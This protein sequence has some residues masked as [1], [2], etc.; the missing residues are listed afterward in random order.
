MSLHLPSYN[1][2]IRSARV[3]EFQNGFLLE[4]TPSFLNSAEKTNYVFKTVE[5]NSSFS[6]EEEFS[7]DLFNEM[8]PAL[9]EKSPSPKKN[10][11]P[12]HPKKQKTI[13]PGPK[14]PRNVIL[15]RPKYRP[16][17]YSPIE[18]RSGSKYERT[19]EPRYYS[20]PGKLNSTSKKKVVRRFQVSPSSPVFNAIIENFPFSP[21]PITPQKITFIAPL[22]N[23]TRLIITKKTDSTRASI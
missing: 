10:R 4:E 1:S 22:E 14:S 6:L 3:E 15:T 13:C 20:N 12:A 17:V 16:S 18:T 8:P 5:I 23:G 9:E 19:A 21:A 2:N 11:R 7:L